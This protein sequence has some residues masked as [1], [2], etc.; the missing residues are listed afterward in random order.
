MGLVSLFLLSYCARPRTRFIAET[1][2]EATKTDRIDF[3]V[4][5]TAAADHEYR[6]IGRFRERDQSSS[7]G[8][9]KRIAKMTVMTKQETALI[10]DSWDLVAQDLKG[11][12][13][14]FFKQ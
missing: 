11:H 1:C 13:L 10:S 5:V 12:G 3:R 6:T 2:T 4:H 14:K 7:R 8:E 9:G